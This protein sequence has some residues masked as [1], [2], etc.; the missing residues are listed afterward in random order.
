[1]GG[2]HYF[3]LRQ[4]GGQIF[5]TALHFTTKKRPMFTSSQ[6][7][8]QPCVASHKWAMCYQHENIYTMHMQTQNVKSVIE[9]SS[10]GEA[11][12]LLLGAGP[13]RV[14]AANLLA[15]AESLGQRPTSPN[16]GKDQRSST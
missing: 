14:Q 3:V 11:L 9:P 1:M 4:R 16:H 10:S 8:S 2:T 12:E 7:S 13:D 15:G 6:P 5:V